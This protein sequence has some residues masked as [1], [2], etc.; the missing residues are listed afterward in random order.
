MVEQLIFTICLSVRS[1]T[2]K[3]NLEDFL[4][5]VDFS[6]ILLAK[7]RTLALTFDV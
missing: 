3:Q 2:R 6:C 5:G 7:V 4:Q 1:H